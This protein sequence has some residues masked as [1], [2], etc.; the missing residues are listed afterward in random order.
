M[1]SYI[2]GLLTGALLF[3]GCAADVE[4][5]P[6]KI[7][8]GDQGGATPSGSLAGS[9]SGGSGGAEPLS[10]P[11]C[12]GS[13]PIHRAPD[14]FAAACANEKCGD[15]LSIYDAHGCERRIC[16]KDSDCSPN[17]QCRYVG[18]APVSCG[19]E[20][21]DTACHCGSIA[22]VGLESHCMPR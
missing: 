7:A 21:S 17:E 18:F 16:V 9:L 20:P 11:E 4:P 15:P 22:A 12:P 3:S 19:Y 5:A 14:C 8:I 1:T 6:A 2:L 13:R 10:I